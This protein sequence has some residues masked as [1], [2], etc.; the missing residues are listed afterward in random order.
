VS[1]CAALEARLSSRVACRSAVS[2]PRYVLA[3]DVPREPP[4]DSPTCVNAT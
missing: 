2:L 3:A 1:G 4:L